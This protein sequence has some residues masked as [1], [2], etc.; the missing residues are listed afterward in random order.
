MKLVNDRRWQNKYQTSRRNKSQLLACLPT[1]ALNSFLIDW[2]NQMMTHWN[3][4]FICFCATF[5]LL[6]TPLL[7]LCTDTQTNVISNS[8]VCISKTTH[9]QHQKKKWRSKKSRWNQSI[10]CLRCKF[11]FSSSASC[12]E[13]ISVFRF[14]KWFGLLIQ[15]R[16]PKRSMS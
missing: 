3:E 14:Q 15:I 5:S 2:K 8:V 1:A 4:W 9:T 16:N 6:F 10:V 11:L 13:M 12:D 7:S